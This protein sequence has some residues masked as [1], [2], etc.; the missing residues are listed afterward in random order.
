MNSLKPF[1][2]YVITGWIVLPHRMDTTQES[3]K[4]VSL[5][6]NS[7][8]RWY[9][10]VQVYCANGKL[11]AKYEYFSRVNKRNHEIDAVVSLKLEA[12][13]ADRSICPLREQKNLTSCYTLCEFLR[14]ARFYYSIVST[15]L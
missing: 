1:V 7:S 11:S 4:S 6:E 13:Y 14:C 10:L 12:L 3:F 15:F 5:H 9:S 2:L 8:L